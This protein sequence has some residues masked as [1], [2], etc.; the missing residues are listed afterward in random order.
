[1]HAV[2]PPDL[3]PWAFDGH[4]VEVHEQV[5]EGHVLGQ[6]VVAA[7][8]AHHVFEF[9]VQHLLLSQGV[10]HQVVD[11]L[12]KGVIGAQAGVGADVWMAT[13]RV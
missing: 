10:D 6:R 12:S 2:D 11:E 9:W 13:Q 4:C 7:L 3:E 1:M 8:A 5:L